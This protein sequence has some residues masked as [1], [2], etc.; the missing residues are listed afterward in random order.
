MVVLPSSPRLQLAAKRLLTSPASSLL[1]SSLILDG[2][3]TTNLSAQLQAKGYAPTSQQLISQEATIMVKDRMDKLFRGEFETGIYPDEW[4]WREGISMPHAAREICNS[5]KSDRL[6]AAIVLNEKIGRFISKVMG[7]ESVRIAQDDLV[8]KVPSTQQDH[9]HS[10]RIDTVGFHQ[11]SAYISNN[12]E[13]YDN[14][15]V[16]LWIA[17]DDVD[18]D[19]GCLE[20][21]V[22]SHKWRPL[23]HRMDDDEV[24]SSTNRSISDF[25]S[26]D[27]LSYRKG[28]STA[29]QL[30]GV[31]AD[32]IEVDMV[33]VKEGYA[34]L[35]HQ[36]VYHGSAPNMR[37][38][39]RRALVAHYLRGGV[40]FR[41]GNGNVPFGGATYIYGRYKRYNSVELDETFFPIIYGKK[42]TEW[43]D[44]Y[45]AR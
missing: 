24:A 45:I 10:R 31:P 8:W 17:L 29:S 20:Y 4:H 18:K 25:H 2:Q 15:S 3:D 6:I 13:P 39:H 32:Q 21:A 44:D 11:D 33:P 38:R 14:N 16:T 37:S 1:P 41:Q 42:R 30:A 22:G 35:H 36:D 26:S 40:S 28:L 34:I 43:L 5:W 19:S 23:Q 12:F 7:W 9:T 27:E